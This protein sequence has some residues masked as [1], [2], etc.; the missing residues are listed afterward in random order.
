MNK[1]L[2]FALNATDPLAKSFLPFQKKLRIGADRKDIEMKWTF[3][4]NFHVTVT[5][6]GE[7]NESELPALEEALKSVCSQYTPFD[8]KIEDIG[9]FPS[10][11]QGR[12][13]WLGVQNKKYLGQLK[14]ALDQELT[15][16]NL[17]D[18][19]DDRVFSPHLTI[20]RF[21]NPHSAKDLIS[22]LK[23]KSFGKLHV[24]EV[25]LY[26]SKLHGAYPTYT[27]LFR[28]S[29]TGINS[30]SETL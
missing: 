29:L 25:V 22:P 5:F 6:L 27:P 21:R 12:V 24:Q 19:K 20:G 2:F 9:A 10:E 4:E 30:I 16:K 8:L 7:R 17:L 15:N 18:N 23:R 14:E 13:L 1:R 26:E 11:D 28:C 3:P